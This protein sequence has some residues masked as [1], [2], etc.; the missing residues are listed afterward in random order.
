MTEIK[1]GTDAIRTAVANRARKGHLTP[2][3]R[4]AGVG[5]AAL[6][7][8]GRGEGK[9]PPETLK[10]LARELLDAVFDAEADRLRPIKKLEPRSLGI[11][12]PP[13]DPE[14][15]PTFKFG[16]ADRG[17]QPVNPVRPTPKVPRPGW[18]E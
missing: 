13:I 4:D 2:L 17:P 1:T 11:R 3:A 14:T 7:S 6:D 10:A 15:L 12:P 16:P 8:F 18:V 9:L 5:T